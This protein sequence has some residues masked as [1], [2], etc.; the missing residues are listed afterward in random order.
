M[1]QNTLTRQALH[2]CF[3][4]KETSSQRTIRYYPDTKLPEE[5]TKTV[6]KTRKW[7][8]DIGITLHEYAWF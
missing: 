8:S 4:T 3:P 5:D 6:G 7:V 2:A 1:Y